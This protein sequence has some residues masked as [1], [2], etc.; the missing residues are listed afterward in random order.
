MR[1]ASLLAPETGLRFGIQYF[2]LGK[3]TFPRY[4]PQPAVG[5]QRSH[6]SPLVQGT[7]PCS[8]RRVGLRP[9]SSWWLSSAHFWP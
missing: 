2:L 5:N 7:S 8:W 3:E 9:L 6:P 4:L 1:S